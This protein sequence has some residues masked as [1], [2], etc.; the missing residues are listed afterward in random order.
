[1]AASWSRQMTG[2]LPAASVAIVDRSE[3]GRKGRRSVSLSEV[4]HAGERMTGPLQTSAG[5]SL[6]SAD[7]ACYWTAARETPPV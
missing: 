1:M 4:E 6:R 7:L 5:R 3:A 2:T